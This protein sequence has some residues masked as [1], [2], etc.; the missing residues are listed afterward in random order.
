MGG[1]FRSLYRGSPQGSRM[2][3][4]NPADLATCGL[5]WC[6]PFRVGQPNVTLSGGVAPGCSL[7]PIQGTRSLAFGPIVRSRVSATRSEDL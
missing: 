5:R 2:P 1:F 4:E 3:A 7:V 6:N